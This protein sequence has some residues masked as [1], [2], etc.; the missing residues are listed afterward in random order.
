MF[1]TKIKT[2]VAVLLAVGLLAGATGVG[3]LSGRTAAGQHDEKPTAENPVEP[4]A[5]Q[6]KDK[7]IVTAWGKEVGGL[8]AGLGFRPGERRAHRHGEEVALVVRVRNVG[9][10]EV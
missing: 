7:E 8:Q 6:E 10:E 3:V 5:K 2:G 4:A 9:R 1:M